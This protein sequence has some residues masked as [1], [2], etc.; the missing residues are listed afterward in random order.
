MAYSNIIRKAIIK[1]IPEPVLQNR[2]CSVRNSH[3][4]VFC[5]KIV[6]K[7]L[8]NV[9]EKY[10]CRS[11]FFIILPAKFSRIAFL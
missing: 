8:V 10:L 2:R 6:L 5:K 11:L 7:K 1:S 9:T 4:K 3:P